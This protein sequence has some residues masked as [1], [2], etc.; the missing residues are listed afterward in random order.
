MRWATGI[1]FYC[2]N[3]F[4][5]VALTTI[6]MK[7][8]EKLVLNHLTAGLPPTLDPYQFA[9]RPNRSTE[10][11][12]STA[13]YSALTHLDKS[14]T[15]IRMLFIDFSSAFNTVLPTVLIT[16]FSELGI[17]TST[18][19]WILDFLTNRPQSVRLG[20]Q[21]S[22]TLILNTGI[23]Q[24]CVL[25]PLLYSLFTHDCAPL[26]NSNIFIKYA[27]DTTVVGQT[28]NAT[29]TKELIVDFRKSNSSRHLQVNIN[30]TEVERVFS[31]KF[32][33]VHI[34]EDL[35]WQQNTSAL[36]KKAQQFLYFLRSHKKSSP[37]AGILT[38]FYRCIIESI[39]TNYITIWYEGSTVCERKA[40]QRVVKNGPTH[41][42]HPTTC[43]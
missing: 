11:A 28:D 5:P 24:G 42:W 23:P 36:V 25:S 31:F 34:S 33:G 20:N 40:L 7:C 15:Y 10:D 22:S 12:V 17:C 9:Y 3:D 1:G 19:R 2:L 13:L 30:G 37:S 8:F 35:S 38:S 21:V 14:N 6:A 39:L 29:K 18:C 4:R 26:Y 27:D 43:H 32:L 16:K 41:H